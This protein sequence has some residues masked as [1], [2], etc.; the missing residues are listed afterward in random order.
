MNTVSR[1]RIARH[2]LVGLLA[3]L[4]TVAG[5]GCGDDDG[6]PVDANAPDDAATTPD[7]AAPDAAPPSRERLSEVGLYADIEN[8][9]VADGV[10]EFEP[11]YRLWSDGAVKTRWIALPPGGQIDTSDMNRWV[12]PVGT[13]FF[14]EFVRD[15]VRV[16][17]RMIEKLGDG[18]MDFWM[19]AFIWEL[20][21][22][23]AVF[24][25]GG[26]TNVNGTEHDVPDAEMCW[27]CHLGEPSKALGF[28]AIQLSRETGPVTLKQIADDGWL[29]DPPPAGVDYP[30]PGDATVSAALGYLHAN[31]GHCHNPRGTSWPDT[32]MWLRLQIEDRTPEET[33]TYMSTLDVPLDR[34]VTGPYTVRVS[35]GDA[36]M[37]AITA[38]MSVRG[39]MAEMPPLATELIDP[40]G[41]AAVT[42]WIDG[43]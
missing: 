39:T 41:I 28:S 25:P 17:T 43:L 15:G 13:K 31:C 1:T 2:L 18:P 27:V 32:S 29:T 21:E 16:E 37:S 12:F 14:K 4:A 9:V 38:R 3:G 35:P 30:A 10:I 24:A 20:D 7:A 23:D 26:G 19:G 6:G 5:G 11:A 42:A 36:S 40:D 8:K 22:S 33:T 34:W